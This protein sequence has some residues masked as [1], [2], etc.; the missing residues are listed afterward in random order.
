[1]TIHIYHDRMPTVAANAY[2]NVPI[3]MGPGGLEPSTDC[4]AGSHSIQAE[5]WTRSKGIFLTLYELADNIKW[6]A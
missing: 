1:M 3:N 2:S 5:L 4:S 6:E